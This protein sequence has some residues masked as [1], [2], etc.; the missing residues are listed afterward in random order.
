MAPMSQIY[1]V[2]A[3]IACLLY[4]LCSGSRT[5][6][7]AVLLLANVFFLTRFGLF[8]PPIIL[9]AAT[10][11]FLVG[12]GLHRAPMK[13]RFVRRLLLWISLIVNVGLLVSAKYIPLRLPAHYAWL[14]PLSL[15]FYCFQS[16]TYTFDAYRKD[17][18]TTR[19][20]LAY[21]S[22]T[23]FFGVIVA[24]PI[25]RISNLLKQ[26]ETPFQL[27]KTA[28][29]RAMLLIGVGLIKKL[30]I[31]DFLAD[32]VVNRIFD[33][34]TLYSGA[35]VLIGVFG[36]ALQ[37][38]YDFSGYTDIAMGIGQFFGLQL[39][40]NF[41]RPY[42]SVSITDF[43]RRWHI[44][45]SNWLR[46]Y[47]YF[48]LPSA[49]RWSALAYIN[50]VITMLLGGLWHG[51]TL[52]FAIW[53]LL[54]GVAL[55]IVR[56]YQNLRGRRTPTWYAKFASGVATFLFVSFTWIF[57]R[58]ATTKEALAVLSRIGSRTFSV[59]NISQQMLIVL[60]VAIL[61][62]VLPKSWYSRLEDYFGRAPFLVQGA[63]LAGMVLLV[64]F[65]AGRGSAPFVY[66]NF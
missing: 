62:H 57:F 47:L 26:L 52:N 38:Y 48:S 58:A 13:R 25:T 65:L 43:W 54:H 55:A 39:P 50:L 37:L 22:A 30:L 21:L 66:S 6:R 41:N 1:F 27:T 49:R 20:Y 34:P 8:Y 35:E 12:L 18:E 17:G 61:F 11:D 46:D 9:V 28:G 53:G 51:L 24:G 19:S 2:Y 33:T 14:F 10:L 63:A 3:G 31:A 60:G 64:Q 5:V 7:L 4:W 32:N 16:L 23:S 36:Y 40:D 45:F 42:L 56:F 15:S 44:T 29:G 59:T